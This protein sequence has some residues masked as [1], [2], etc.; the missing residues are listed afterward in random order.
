MTLR[1]FETAAEL[2]ELRREQRLTVELLQRSPMRVGTGTVKL[3]DLGPDPDLERSC[4]E[5]AQSLFE[6]HAEYLQALRR[7]E[8]A[9]NVVRVA[10]S[11]S[12]D[13][14]TKA[15]EKSLEEKAAATVSAVNVQHDDL[16]RLD[17]LRDAVALVLAAEQLQPV[18]YGVDALG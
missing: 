11:L 18:G 6:T 3:R 10:R 5:A 9:W 17:D 15:A 7:E 4:R 1:L 14:W 16:A 12:G 8:R 2:E 13:D